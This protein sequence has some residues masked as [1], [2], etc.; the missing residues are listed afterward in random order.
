MISLT[1]RGWLYANLM[2]LIFKHQ[3]F[4]FAAARQTSLTLLSFLFSSLEEEE[5]C[6]SQPPQ[7]HHQKRICFWQLELNADFNPFRYGTTLTWWQPQEWQH[8]RGGDDYKAEWWTKRGWNREVDKVHIWTFWG[9]CLWM[10]VAIISEC[11]DLKV[12]DEAKLFTAAFVEQLRDWRSH[13]RT[14]LVHFHGSSW[15]WLDN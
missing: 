2:T 13:L 15:C 8:W 10:D 4:S 12:F 5:L 6:V 11:M 9:L 14:W 3:C 7:G 1:Y